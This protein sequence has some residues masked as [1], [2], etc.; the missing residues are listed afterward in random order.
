MK[1]DSKFEI[2]EKINAS[3]CPKDNKC[4]KSKFYDICKAEDIGLESFII[5]LMKNPKKCV[6]SFSFGDTYFCKC[7]L[8]VY[9][10]KEFQR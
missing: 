8:R 9:I 4:C 1:K 3:I 6:C 5:C 7:P 10:S 2:Q